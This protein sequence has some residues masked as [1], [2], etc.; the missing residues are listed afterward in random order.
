MRLVILVLCV[1]FCSANASGQERLRK[2]MVGPYGDQ[3]RVVV[4]L[5]DVTQEGYR[6]QSMIIDVA[7]GKTKG[8]D[9]SEVK[10]DLTSTVRNLSSGAK[11]QKILI[12]R[13]K[14]NG[15]L[16]LKC[17]GTWSKHETNPALEKVIA[18]T[19][20]VIGTVDLNAK[21][22]TEFKLSTDLEEKVSVLFDSLGTEDYPCLRKLN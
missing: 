6:L 20:T 5:T 14:K 22:P 16:E 17:D 3:V 10:L 7:P 1:C 19:R 21:T 2:A 8:E 13:W 12:L 11:N 18:L 4:A 9:A 15:E